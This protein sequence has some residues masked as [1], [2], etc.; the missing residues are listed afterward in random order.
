MPASGTGSEKNFKIF[1]ADFPFSDL[2]WERKKLEESSLQV[3]I[4]E[5]WCETAEEVIAKAGGADALLVHHAPVTAAVIEE[6]DELKVIGRYGAGY[7]VVDVRAAEAAGIP[8]INDPTYCVEELTAHVLALM[9]ALNRK[10]LPLSDLVQAA[11][12]RSD[13]DFR[14]AGE[15]H[16]LA[17]QKLGVIGL[18]RTGMRLAEKA[19]ALGLEL[20]VW[21]RRAEEKLASRFDLK[22]L[23]A[24]ELKELLEKADIISLHLPLT[25]ETEG[26]IGREEFELMKEDAILINTARGGLLQEKALVTALTEGEIAGAGLDVFQK[27]PL[28]ADHPLLRLAEERENL[29]LTPHA[30]FYSEEAEAELRESI[31]E[32]V[33]AALQG[34]KPD[35]IVNDEAW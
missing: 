33:I 32:Q 15:I 31:L 11:E 6:L 20:L 19:E 21:D 12:W 1:W 14:S 13:E 26:I 17:G 24:A 28:P 34:E 7:D 27:E 16:R 30:A 9:L 8:V 10:I 5:E 23:R 29:I 2:Q 25:S 18:G 22:N 4:E 35:H 3:E